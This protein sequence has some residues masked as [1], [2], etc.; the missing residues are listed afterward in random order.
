[1]NLSAPV[2]WTLVTNL[3]LTIYSINSHQYTRLI[4]AEA[5]IETTSDY[6]GRSIWAASVFLAARPAALGADVPP[7]SAARGYSLQPR[8]ARHDSHTRYI[9]NA[10]ARVK[11]AF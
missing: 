5:N 11:A 2:A 8:R 3:L 9:R 6:R 4:H 10:P 1:Q 7:H